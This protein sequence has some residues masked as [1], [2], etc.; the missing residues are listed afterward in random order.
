[1]LSGIRRL[2]EGRRRREAKQ[3]RTNEREEGEE[4][5][6]G[7]S[8]SKLLPSTS[9]DSKASI[10]RP[11][12]RVRPS[13]PSPHSKENYFFSFRSQTNSGQAQKRQRELRI[14]HE[15]DVQDLGGPSRNEIGE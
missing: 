7:P 3:R 10:V 8:L 15:Y 4:S 12:A 9:D 6:Q 1:M 2:V 11:V 5:E 13:A 14:A